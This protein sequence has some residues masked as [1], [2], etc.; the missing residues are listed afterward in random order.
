M[1]AL[2]RMALD[3]A[4]G[5]EVGAGSFALALASFASAMQLVNARGECR[6][7]VGHAEQFRLLRVVG[8]LVCTSGS[9]GDAC[10]STLK[11]LRLSGISGVCSICGDLPFRSAL[12]V[13]VKFRRTTIEGVERAVFVVKESCSKGSVAFG[14]NESSS[15]QCKHHLF[16][17][18]W[19]SRS[20][21][22]I[23]QLLEGRGVRAPLVVSD[24]LS[25]SDQVHHDP[26]LGDS[27]GRGK[28]FKKSVPQEGAALALMR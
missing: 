23:N 2:R 20:I 5:A 13:A 22:G 4:V 25:S 16:N 14:L 7:S 19:R 12:E 28:T 9:P 11:R 24:R 21:V 8:R 18:E 10:S 17:R 6:D 27:L 1:A 26:S 3:L 15:H